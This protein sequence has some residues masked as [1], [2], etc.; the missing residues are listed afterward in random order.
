M[1]KFSIPIFEIQ[2]NM[3]TVYIQLGS[4]IG[5]RES[6]IAKSIEQIKKLVFS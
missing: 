2:I 4:N 3:N 5:K 1:N 6:Y